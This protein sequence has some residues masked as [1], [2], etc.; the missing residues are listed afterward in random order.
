MKIQ[1]IVKDYPAVAYRLGFLQNFTQTE[2][3]S[4]T[5]DPVIKKD[6]MKEEVDVD[7]EKRKPQEPAVGG[8]SKPV[9]PTAGLSRE[10]GD[11]GKKKDVEGFEEPEDEEEDQLDAILKEVCM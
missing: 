10:E 7:N 8:D 2:Q 9:D 5:S 4:L 1:G 3:P 11:G 6:L